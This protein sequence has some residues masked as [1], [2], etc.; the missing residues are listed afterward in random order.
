MFAR[1]IKNYLQRELRATMTRFREPLEEPYRRLVI[2][3]LNVVFGNTNADKFWEE[4]LKPEL[5]AKFKGFDLDDDV[6]DLRWTKLFENIEKP[7]S[8]SGS[9][10]TIVQNLRES[11]LRT[12]LGEH[13]PSMR[14]I[15]VGFDSIFNIPINGR[16]MLLL[17]LQ[18][19]M[20]LRFTPRSQNQ[21][22]SNPQ[23]L[24]V[25]RPFVSFFL[26]LYLQISERMDF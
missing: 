14:C 7:R 19:L 16:L 24:M 20:G 10:G 13:G 26:F 18:K 12:S 22:I 17:R 8:R 6:A 23:H 2:K 21:F 5:K 4:H 9:G 3:F 1:T 15:V 11:D 25:S